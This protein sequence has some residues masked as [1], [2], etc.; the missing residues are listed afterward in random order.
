MKHKEHFKHYV[1]EHKIALGLAAIV[2][3]ALIIL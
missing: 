3:I 2:I 1:K